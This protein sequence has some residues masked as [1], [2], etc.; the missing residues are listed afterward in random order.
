MKTWGGPSAGSVSGSVL[1]IPA[2]PHGRAQ[3]DRKECGR[4]EYGNDGRTCRFRR[5][6][7][8]F[9]FSSSIFSS[10]IFL[11]VIFLSVVGEVLPREQKQSPREPPACPR[12]PLPKLESPT[13]ERPPNRALWHRSR[14]SNRDVKERRAEVLPRQ[15][16]ILAD[17]VAQFPAVFVTRW[18]SEAA[19]RVREGKTGKGEKGKDQ[20]VKLP[21]SCF[22][23]LPLSAFRFP[24]SAFPTLPPLPPCAPVASGSSHV[25]GPRRVSWEMG[26]GAHAKPPRGKGRKEEEEEER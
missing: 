13:Y 8:T 18:P 9:I 6:S 4:N 17:G 23:V 10:S 25:K 1:A 24:L 19:K 5:S 15:E 26:E 14:R 7:D 21:A 12:F 16:S 11:S 22:V 3:S 20:S 2:L